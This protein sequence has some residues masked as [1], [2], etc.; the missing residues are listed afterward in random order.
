M[1]ILASIPNLRAYEL[2]EYRSQLTRLGMAAGFGSAKAA[3]ALAAISADVTIEHAINP[4]DS[5]LQAR[6]AATVEAEA[7]YL[8]LAGSTAALDR[9]DHELARLREAAA[10]KRKDCP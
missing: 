2:A 10:S 5:D 7:M 3:K 9:A 1:S 4:G 8:A 6:Y